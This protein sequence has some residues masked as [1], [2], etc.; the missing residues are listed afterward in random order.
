M[1]KICFLAGAIA[2][3]FLDRSSRRK[4]YE[5]FEDYSFDSIEFRRML[6]K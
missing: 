6:I 1:L 3:F 4:E 2:V 5:C